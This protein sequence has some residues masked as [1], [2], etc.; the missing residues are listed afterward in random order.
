MTV[1]RPTCHGSHDPKS[2]Y[3]GT[4]PFPPTVGYAWA[5]SVCSQRR[6]FGAS[7]TTLERPAV[8]RSAFYWMDGSWGPLAV[9]LRL[10]A[11]DQSRPGTI[12]FL[13]SDC[14]DRF[15]AQGQAA[16]HRGHDV[17]ELPFHSAWDGRV[18]IWR[19]AGDCLRRH[20][21]AVFVCRPSA[22]IS[23]LL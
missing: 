4:L 20:T 5:I 10:D 19:D 1:L 9:E 22:H 7:R 17:R 14:S 11:L 21:C 2:N 13:S 3:F 12:C 6:Y 8:A 18:G 23:G 16:G 15:Q